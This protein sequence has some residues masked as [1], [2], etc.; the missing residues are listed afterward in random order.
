MWT[1][2][3]QALVSKPTL[4]C[5][6]HLDSILLCAVY[7]ICKVQ[8]DISKRIKFDRILRAY[9]NMCRKRSTGLGCQLINEHAATDNIELHLPGKRGGIIDFYN[10]V[11][12]PE[13][14]HFI[15]D[16]RAL[17]KQMAEMSTI[18]TIY[19]IQHVWNNTS[20]I[21]K[22]TD[23]STTAAQPRRSLLMPSNLHLQP[24]GTTNEYR[25]TLHIVQPLPFQWR[26]KEGVKHYSCL[27]Y[28]KPGVYVTKMA[29]HVEVEMNHSLPLTVTNPGGHI[30]T[31]AS[32]NCEN[33]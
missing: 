28:T 3:Y 30:A 23:L 18:K 29:S 2:A 20:G 21:V 13:M 33:G 27:G 4:L 14:K 26:Y 10:H 31:A 19:D 24:L 16:F 9:G 25:R 22:E 5:N 15:L 12:I 6:R 7:S 17:E 11:F 1:V 8:K 32:I